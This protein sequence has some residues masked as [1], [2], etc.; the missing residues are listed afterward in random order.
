MM[1]TPGLDALDQMERRRRDAAADADAPI[2]E[3]RAWPDPPAPEAYHGLAGDIV[4]AIEPHTEA[5]PVALLAHVLVGYGSVIGRSARY[6]V[7][8]SDHYTT[9][10]V[11]LVGRTAKGRKGTAEARIRRLLRAVDEEWERDH[12]VSGLSSGEGLI[13]A[14]RDPIVRMERDRETGEVE[15]VLADAGIGDKRLLVVEPEYA[16]T[17]R[18]LAREGN[19]LSPVIRRAWD[20]AGALRTLTK[21]S[22]ACATGAHISI[23]GHITEAELRTYLDR[24]EAG[25]GYANR[26]LYLCVRRA[27]ELPHGGGSPDVAPLIRRLTAAVDH[28]RQAGTLAMD[29]DA[30]R[31]WE[32]VYSDLSRE[33]DGLLGAVTARA[34]AHAVRLATLYALLDCADAIRL[35]HLLAAL[36]VWAYA[37]RSAAYVWGDALG[38]PIA[39]EILGALR[40]SP[41]GMTR[42]EIRDLLG[43]N[44]ARGRVTVALGALL[45]AGRARYERHPTHGRPVERW[46]AATE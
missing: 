13:W 1:E 23:V 9:E 5:D 29:A 37:E 40:R 31:A 6:V 26:Y 15:E 34:E 36:A 24:T 10:Y 42:T 45:R 38:D 21:Q 11:V 43:R 25:N 2:P 44:A 17:L 32:E 30:R 8:D 46:Y 22:P 27:R 28:G 18:V 7:E 35:E 3:P 41:E 12:V 39:D 4:R 20:G 14:V 33:R 19:T 16:S